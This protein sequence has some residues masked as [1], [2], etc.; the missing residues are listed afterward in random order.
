MS[1]RVRGSRPM[2]KDYAK[3]LAIHSVGDVFTAQR[4]IEKVG[5]LKW[6]GGAPEFVFPDFSGEI[7][8]LQQVA[9]A[10]KV[11]QQENANA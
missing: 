1:L 5:K 2:R 8:G 10:L 7:A 6:I 11:A 9:D 3:A 4:L